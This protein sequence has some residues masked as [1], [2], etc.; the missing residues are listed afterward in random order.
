MDLLKAFDCILH[1]LLIAKLH[2]YEF[3]FKILT[4]LNRY[5]RNRKQCIKINNIRSYFLKTLS[6]VPQVSILG[7]IS[8]NIFL[9]LTTYSYALKKADIITLQSIMLL[10]RSIIS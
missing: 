5:L 6:C 7:P 3:S 10:K 4:F 8:F 9:K 1:D 2:A